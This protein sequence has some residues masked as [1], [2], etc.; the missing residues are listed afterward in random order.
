MMA[1]APTPKHSPEIDACLPDSA[2]AGLDGEQRWS[3]LARARA[4]GSPGLVS[5]AEDALFR[6]YRPLAAAMAAS[7]AETAA[8][9]APAGVQ[10]PGVAELEQ[11]AEL[12][13]AQAVLAWRRPDGVGFVE[14]VRRAIGHRLRVAT[15]ESRTADSTAAPGLGRAAWTGAPGHPGVDRRHSVEVAMLDRTGVI[16]SVNDAW[17]EFSAANGGNGSRTGVGMSYLA[18]CDAA[19]DDINARQ[20]AAAIRAAASGDL[21]APVTMVIPCHAPEVLRWYDVLVAPRLDR[22]FRTIG[23]VV[24]LSLR[25]ARAADQSAHGARAGNRPAVR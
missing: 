11:A 2:A 21:P 7:A 15:A 17:R 1:L 23:V 20:V 13:L 19:G 22:R 16:T 14:S 9:A 4:D 3:I 18:V 10:P 12:G 25:T 5:A 8:A 24:T 6:C